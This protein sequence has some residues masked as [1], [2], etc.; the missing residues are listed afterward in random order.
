[1]MAMPN[2]KSILIAGLVLLAFHL[3]PVAAAQSLQEQ[4]QA[5]FRQI[6]AVHGLSETRMQ[7]IRG[8]FS[9]SGFIG[10]GNPAITSHPVTPDS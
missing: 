8:L 7:E 10:Q 3:V 1:M 2:P 9:R 6:E 4:N 5:L